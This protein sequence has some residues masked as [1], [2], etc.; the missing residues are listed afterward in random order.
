MFNLTPR[1]L[2]TLRPL[3]TP[4]K[5]QDFLET[6]KSYEGRPASCASPRLTI[7][8][9]WAT[10]LEG[11]LLGALA[12]RERGLTPLLLDLTATNYDF[13]HVIAPFK[14]KGCW[15]ALSKSNHAVLRYR[16]PVY[17]SI[18]ELVMSYFH[19]YTDDYGD[20][21]LRSYSNPVNLKIFDKQ[22]WMTS[23]KPLWTI[24][25]RLY[26]VKHFSILTA[27]QRASLRPIDPIEIKSGRLKIW[28]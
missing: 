5:I 21:S 2:K 9:G 20:K 13:D 3:T 11:A 28:P 10:C 1:E 12:L 14:I 7:K 15:G 26:T 22:N 24:E 18:R 25:K 19:E 16:D 23:E 4:R 8:K 6:L 27:S 17:K